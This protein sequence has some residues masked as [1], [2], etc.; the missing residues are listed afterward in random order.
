[1]CVESL[2][3]TTGEAAASPQSFDSSGS[4]DCGFPTGKSLNKLTD[5]HTLACMIT[6]THTHT[7]THPHTGL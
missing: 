4:F 1:M 2:V 3:F 7:H 5:V 6:H